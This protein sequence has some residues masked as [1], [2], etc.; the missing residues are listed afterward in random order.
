MAAPGHFLFNGDADGILAQHIWELQGHRPLS[1]ITGLKR[2]IELLQRLPSDA[3]GDVHVFDISLKKNHEALRTLLTKPDIHVTWFDHH[4]P[5]APLDHPRLTRHIHESANTC[6]GI[7]VNAYLKHRFPLW[8][9]AAA[10]GDNLPEAARAL[11]ANE[12]LSQTQIQALEELGFLLNYNAY[13]ESE[14]DVHTPAVQVAELLSPFTDPFE[15]LAAT[16]LIPQLREQFQHDKL[17]ALGSQPAL[18][19][20]H[21][22]A[23]VLPGERWARRYASSWANTLAQEQPQRAQAMCMGNQDGTYMVSIR[24]PRAWGDKGPSA[25]VLASEFPTG[26]GR[27]LAAGINRLPADR[28]ETFLKRFA[29]YY[30]KI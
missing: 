22:V 7:I 27:R 14:A 28:L 11:V 18:D 8:A 2:D 12:R 21:A 17:Q 30:R 3:E 6:T 4:E 25:A 13:G 20:K 26:G 15:F 23:Y 1:R 19:S 5:G 29:E 16:D 10:F 9:A 24:S